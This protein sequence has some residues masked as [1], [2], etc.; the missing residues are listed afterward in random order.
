MYPNRQFLAHFVVDMPLCLHVLFG[1]TQEWALQL[2]AW[3]PPGKQVWLHSWLRVWHGVWQLWGAGL[4][5]GLAGGTSPCGKQFTS[6][7]SQVK[8]NF[9]LANTFA[10]RHTCPPPPPPAQDRSFA[11]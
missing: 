1:V 3:L 5:R 2:Q 10:S 9:P 7:T 8:Y 11:Q 4:A 6:E